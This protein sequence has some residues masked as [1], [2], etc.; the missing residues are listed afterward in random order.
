[1]R[2]LQIAVGTTCALGVVVV[3]IRER[4]LKIISPDMVN[5]LPRARSVA[6]A[7]PDISKL[8]SEDNSRPKNCTYF[9]SNP[10]FRS[11]LPPVIS[12]SVC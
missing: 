1:M 2:V 5:H 12:L 8:R 10:L 7:K 11:G 9:P 3:A 4:F 6:K